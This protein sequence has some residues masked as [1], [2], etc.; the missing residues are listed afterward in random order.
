MD[1]FCIVTEEHI[2]YYSFY[3]Y[4]ALHKVNELIID[5]IYIVPRFKRNLGLCKDHSIHYQILFTV[6]CSFVSTFS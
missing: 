5:C 4:L 1:Y 3:T 2:E 6:D